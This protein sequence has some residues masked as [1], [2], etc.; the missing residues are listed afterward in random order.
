MVQKPSMSKQYVLEDVCTGHS[1]RESQRRLDVQDQGSSDRDREHDSHQPWQT[2]Q[3]IKDTALEY[4]T[5]NWYISYLAG[6][7]WQH[8]NKPSQHT[9]HGLTSQQPHSRQLKLSPSPPAM[10]MM[11]VSAYLKRDHPSKS[12]SSS[13]SLMMISAGKVKITPAARDSPALAAVCTRLFSR[14][15]ESVEFGNRN[16][17]KQGARSGSAIACY[18]WVCQQSVLSSLKLAARLPYPHPSRRGSAGWTC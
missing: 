1:F 7:V 13:S 12:P 14:M 4:H 17:L 3:R 18:E 10:A 15:P 9:A 5:E 11:T 2:E 8:T 16:R 6:E